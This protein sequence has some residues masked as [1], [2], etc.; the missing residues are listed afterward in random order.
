[1]DPAELPPPVPPADVPPDPVDEPELGNVL[2]PPF[3]CCC[4]ILCFSCSNVGL[5]NGGNLF[6][7]F[8]INFD[9]ENSKFQIF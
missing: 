8:F 5:P 2:L 4:S 3:L 9:F 7:I 1:M 6:A